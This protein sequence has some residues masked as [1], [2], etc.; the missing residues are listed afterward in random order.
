MQ[1]S[2][3][4]VLSQPSG[5]ATSAPTAS[6]SPPSWENRIVSYALVDAA[7]LTAHPG[8]FRNHPPVQVEALLGSLNDL[9]WIAPVIVSQQSGR[10]LDGHLRAEL[11]DKRGGP[12]PVAY[13]DLSEEEEREALLTL[14]PI[15]ALA[16]IDRE[17]LGELLDQVASEEQ[18]IR[19]LLERLAKDNDLYHPR[20]EDPGPDLDHAEELQA[21]WKVEPGHLYQV[22]QHR[23]LCEDVADPQA[24][25]RLLGGTLAHMCVTDPPWNVAYGETNHPAWRKRAIVNDNLGNDFPAF[26]ERFSR[27]IADSL[28]PGGLLY[29]VMSAQ[30]WPTIDRALREAGMHWSC[31]VIWAKDRPVLSRKD[32]HTQYEPIWY[33]WKTGARRLVSV[34][35]RSQSDLWQIPR[36]ARSDEHPTMKPVEL[37]SRTLLNSS[38]PGDVVLDPFLGSGTTAVAAEQTG[39]CCVALEIEP[40]YVAVS[41]E[42]L[43]GM[44]LTPRRVKEGD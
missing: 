5:T 32:Y 20:G 10:I 34:E 16:T 8:N 26:A 36:P 15:A 7:E 23:L 14:D 28:F 9:G 27:M 43:T 6:D 11:A 30:E 31:T 4:S 29:L 2:P 12:L 22:G 3:I 42:R 21:K 35:D 37:V 19:Q 18:G 44:G 39:R 1:T 17:R 33:G 24:V 41:L 13:V 25:A 38:R 40:K